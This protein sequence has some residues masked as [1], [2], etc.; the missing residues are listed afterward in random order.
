MSDPTPS[1]T[2]TEAPS[3]APSATPAPGL[4][5]PERQYLATVALAQANARLADVHAQILAGQ[6]DPHLALFPVAAT[7]FASLIASGE[8]EDRAIPVAVSLAIR[9]VDEVRGRTL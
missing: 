5:L 6:Q 8:R 7:L 3:P 4:S 1:P 9:L 2:P